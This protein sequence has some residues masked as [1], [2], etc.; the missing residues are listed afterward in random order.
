MLIL[1][2]TARNAHLLGV[3]VVTFQDFSAQAK[4]EIIRYL[5]LTGHAMLTNAKMK[6]DIMLFKEM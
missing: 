1:I 4:A 6:R 5:E 2:P 3:F